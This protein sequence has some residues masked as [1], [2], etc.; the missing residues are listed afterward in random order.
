MALSKRKLA[1]RDKLVEQHIFWARCIASKAARTL[2][3]WFTADDLIGPAEAALLELATKY[4]P[5][6]GIPFRA[7]ASRIIFQRCIGSVRG[8]EYVERSHEEITPE[9]RAPEAE[10]AEPGAPEQ[11][12]DKVWDLPAEQFRVIQLHYQ[13]DLPMEEAARRIGVC[14]SRA[15][16]IHMAALDAL[17][18]VVKKAA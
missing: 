15:S 8:R 13:H 2:P 18:G 1:E 7:Y 9:L 5:K 16:Q 11:L 14:P 4:E 3:T 12:W 17:R 10:P 6:R